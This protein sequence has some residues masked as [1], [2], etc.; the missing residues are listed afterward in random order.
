MTAAKQLRGQKV[1]VI[2]G[3]TGMGL[4]TAQA[5]L[6]EGAE[7]VVASRSAGRLQVEFDGAV[8]AVT[9]DVAD[10]RQVAA[11]FERV[12]SLDHLVVTSVA[13]ASGSVVDTNLERARGVFET[14]FWGSVHAVRHAVPRMNPTG[15]HHVVLRGRGLATISRRINQRCGEWGSRVAG[16]GADRG[17]GSHSGERDLS[18]AH[19][20]SDL[21]RR[22]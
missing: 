12:D 1:V 20:H 21:G 17:F 6:R 22:R 14:K 10:E 2:G 9:L 18:R 7:V 16:S 13:R 3:R 5:A 4:A 11:F 15:V 8:E 19:S